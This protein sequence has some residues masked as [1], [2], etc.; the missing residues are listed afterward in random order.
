[1]LVEKCQNST[2]GFIELDGCFLRYDTKYFYNF[3]EGSQSNSGCGRPNFDQPETFAYA[4]SNVLSNITKTAVQSPNLFN[5]SVFEADSSPSKRI[6]SLA[7]CWTDLSQTSCQSC[8]SAGLSNI[9]GC[10][11]GALGAQ[12]HT[13]GCDLRYEIY[14]FFFTPILSPPA[15]PLSGIF[16]HIV[17]NDKDYTSFVHFSEIKHGQFNTKASCE[18][19]Q[20]AKNVTCLR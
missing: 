1:M 17:Y 10:S 12:F 11:I 20:N 6:Y 14:Q 8:L 18:N 19:W 9:S 3:T 15:S 16:F 5:A 4:V 2:S 13:M 7:Q